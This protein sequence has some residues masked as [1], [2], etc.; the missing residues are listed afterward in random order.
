MRIA[1]SGAH[2]TGKSTLLAELRTDLRSYELREEPYYELLEEGHAFSDRPSRDEIETQLERSIDQLT[3]PGCDVLF[4]RCPADFL[5]YLLALTP[6]PNV[7]AGWMDN[8]GKAMGTLDLVVF[9]P[10]EHP[11]RIAAADTGDGLREHVDALL[12]G[13]IVEDNFGFGVPH[14]EVRGTLENRVRRVLAALQP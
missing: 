3:S 2:V 4:D 5:A 1:I 14:L 6:E 9:V 10:V 12:R 11:E 7:A 8:I 13:I